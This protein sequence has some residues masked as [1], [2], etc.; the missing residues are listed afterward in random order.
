MRSLLVR[1]AVLLALLLLTRQVVDRL[2]ATE[3][4]LPTPL[5]AFPTV[6][7]DWQGGDAGELAPEIVRTLGVDDYLNRV[8]RADGRS[9]VAL[10]VAFYGSQHEGD[11]IHSPLNCLPGNGWQPISHGR[12]R[13]I[14]AGTPVVNRYV[15]QKRGSRQLVLYWFQGRGRIVASEYVNK[16]FLLA[17]AL[18]LGRTDGTL[19]RVMT[20]VH[21]DERGAENVAVRFAQALEPR[22][23]R[24]LP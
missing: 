5:S 21:T 2:H 9:T 18:R 22:L 10:Y 7:D 14:T 6:L 4:S 13:L 20:P 11:A 12:A 8:Y 15:V 17:D 24:W 3:M 1:T 23:Q 19:V 16:L